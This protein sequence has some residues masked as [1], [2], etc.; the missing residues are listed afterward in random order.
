LLGG[1]IYAWLCGPIFSAEDSLFGFT[2]SEEQKISHR[3]VFFGELALAVLVVMI[4]IL[5]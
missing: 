4:T 3:L 2:L 1:L 5:M